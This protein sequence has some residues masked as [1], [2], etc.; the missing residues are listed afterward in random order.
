MKLKKKKIILIL[1]VIV[2][3]IISISIHEHSQSGLHKSSSEKNPSPLEITGQFR[4]SI[5]QS[6]EIISK[7]AASI[8]GRPGDSTSKKGDYLIEGIV[9]SKDGVSRDKNSDFIDNYYLYIRDTS[10][11]LRKFET[12]EYN[13]DSVKPGDRIFYKYTSGKNYK[14]VVFPAKTNPNNPD[15]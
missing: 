15:Q 14:L 13:Y 6:A 10:G 7:K 4:N 8:S 11:R 12:T 5:I 1:L 3:L 2:L 9:V